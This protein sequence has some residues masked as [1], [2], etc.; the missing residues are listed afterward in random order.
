MSPVPGPPPRRPRSPSLPGTG[1][2]TRR[3]PPSCTS[4]PVSSSGTWATCSQN[5]ASP[6]AKT[7]A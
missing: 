3:S 6:P 5:S 4:T 2:P 7:S 1:T